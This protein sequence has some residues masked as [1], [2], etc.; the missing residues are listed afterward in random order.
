MV[1]RDVDGFGPVGGETVQRDAVGVVGQEQFPIA[2]AHGEARPPVGLG[3]LTGPYPEN[4]SC[5]FDRLALE[6]GEQVFTVAAVSGRQREARGGAEGGQ[7]I[8]SGEGG[9]VVDRAGGC[10]AGPAHEEGH[11]HAA[12]E[13]AAFLAAQAA[14]RADAVV[15]AVARAPGVVVAGVLLGFR[16]GGLRA[17]V[18]G[19]NHDR[20][21]RNS[22]GLQRIEHAADGVV[23]IGDDGSVDAFLFVEVLP[24]FQR[25]LRGDVGQVALVEPNIEEERAVFVGGDKFYGVFRRGVQI[26]GGGFGAAVEN[27]ELV[28]AV[29]GGCGC[30]VGVAVGEVPFAEVRGAVTGLLEK[31]RGSGRTRVQPVGHVAREILRRRGKVLVNAEA[32]GKH[33][34]HRG[35]AAGRAHGIEDVELVEVGAFARESV[36]VRRPQPRVPVR[37]EIAP[38]PVVGENEDDVGWRRVG[39]GNR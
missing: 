25:C 35:G 19:E 13:E 27:G 17:I 22:G 2:V 18:A 10:V 6:R 7:Q 23:A 31:T 21:L 37:R 32:R 3:G 15:A 26:G 8:D 16:R 24:F 33:A 29:G 34:R 12:L 9:C 20:I 30:A 39:G 28:E 1:L 14:A 38:A 4:G 5:A 11:A 36:E